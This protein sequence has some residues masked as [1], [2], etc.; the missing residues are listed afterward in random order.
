MDVLI[1]IGDQDTYH[2]AE[3]EVVSS[4][5]WLADILAAEGLTGPFV[6]HARRAETLGEQGRHDVIRALRRHEIGLHG[7][8]VHPVMPEI[9]E[10]M[11]WHDG[12]A[13]LLA[14]EG[15]EL[16]QLGRIFDVAPLCSSQHRTHAAPQIFGVARQLGLP[17]LFG[18]PSAPPGYSVSWYAGAPSVPFVQ[19]GAWNVPFVNFA[20]DFLGFLRQRCTGT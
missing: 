11:A 18:S 1:V 7:R 15:S 3:A 2:E 12:V 13:A 14:V 17:Y 16:R 8:D 4:P 19:L 20:P 6:L 10:G 5:I 9:V